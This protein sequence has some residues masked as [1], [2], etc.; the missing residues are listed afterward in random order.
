M[1]LHG[2]LAQI[3]ERNLYPH[4][5]YGAKGLPSYSTYRQHL[6]L[7]LLCVPRDLTVRDS[8]QPSHM[9]T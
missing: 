4:L 9:F 3:T 1:C 5:E 8:E 2:S 7:S 6:S